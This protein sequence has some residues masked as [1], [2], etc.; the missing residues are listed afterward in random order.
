MPPFLQGQYCIL[1][2]FYICHDSNQFPE[3]LVKLSGS[4]MEKSLFT[5]SLFFLLWGGLVTQ[6]NGHF[7]FLKNQFQNQFWCSNRRNFFL[8]YSVLYWHLSFSVTE[9]SNSNLSWLQIS[10]FDRSKITWLIAISRLKDVF[11]VF[12]WKTKE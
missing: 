8:D 3:L 1:P 7:N 9:N 11:G 6:P 2:I 5:L 4:W 12:F 10:H